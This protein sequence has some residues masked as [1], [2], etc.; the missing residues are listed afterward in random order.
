MRCENEFCIYWTEGGCLLPSVSLDI[1][2][3]CTDCIYVEIKKT[4]LQEERARLL[5][6]YNG[7]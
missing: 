5:R 2:G 1:Q 7:E 4:T 6:Q 3:K